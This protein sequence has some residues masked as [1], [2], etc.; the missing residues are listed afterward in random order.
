M[1]NC[2][3]CNKVCKNPNSQRYYTPDFYLPDEDIY[4]EIKGYKTIKDEAKWSQ[5]PIDKRLKVLFDK[6]IRYYLRW[7]FDPSQNIFLWF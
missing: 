5:F 1:L 4:I 6:G 7:L 3:F 2:Q